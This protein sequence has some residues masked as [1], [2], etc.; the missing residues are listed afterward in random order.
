MVLKMIGLQKCKGFAPS[1]FQNDYH[2]ACNELS[3]VVEILLCKYTFQSL[4][5]NMCLE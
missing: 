1:S 5:K 2:L 4:W 3:G